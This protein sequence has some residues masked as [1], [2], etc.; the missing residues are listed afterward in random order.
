MRAFIRPPVLILLFLG[1]TPVDRP[2]ATG[3]CAPDD[4]A[5]NAVTTAGTDGLAGPNLTGGAGAA[6]GA[7]GVVANGANDGGTNSSGT[8]R[9][10]AGG[11][12]TNANTSAPNGN[13]AN[14]TNGAMLDMAKCGNGT[15]DMG[16]TCDPVATCP[17][18]ATCTSTNA[19]L[20]PVLLGMPSMCNA[21]CEV[22]PIEQCMPDDGCCPA[23]CNISTDNDCSD[24]CGDGVLGKGETC[25][26]TSPTMPCPTSCDDM[27]P[28]TKDT[29]TGTPAQCN[30]ECVHTPIT[31]PAAG[32]GCCPDGAH[33]NNDSDCSAKCGNGVKEAGETCDGATCAMN[34]DDNNKCTND[35]TVGSAA[36]CDVKCANDPIVPC[37]GNGKR[38]SGETCDGADC[39]KS[40]STSAKCMK[41]VRIGSATNCDVDCREEAVVP[42]CGNGRTELGETCDGTADCAARITCDDGNPCTQD[43]YALGTSAAACNLRCG[44]HSPIGG[45]TMNECGGCSKLP[46]EFSN[47][48]ICS[49]GSRME[50]R[51]AGTWECSGT[52]SV[53]CRN[54]VQGVVDGCEPIPQ[55]DDDCDGKVDENAPGGCAAP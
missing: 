51:L 24:S 3:D 1:C 40:C 17:S 31:Q 38:E 30:V 32:D 49:V 47:K 54:N 10:G 16:E 4:T 6:N 35:H 44:A 25:E 5:C 14:G 33:T 12:G 26:P 42:C 19:C 53:R 11:N 20:K 15:V 46:P 37:C 13:G 55:G 29:Q 43:A 48:G 21:T 28:C 2:I 7:A 18:D 39:N 50:C 23:G 9:N 41:S 34:C 22:A 45:G 27:D 36:N 8:G 52:N